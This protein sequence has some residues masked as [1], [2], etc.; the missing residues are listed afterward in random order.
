VS[1]LSDR[2]MDEV[3]GLPCV[4]C[5]HLGRGE[6]YGVE[7]HHLFDAHQRSDWLIAPLCPECH[8][9]PNGFHGLGGEPP[10]RRRYKVGEVELLAMTL[11]RFHKQRRAA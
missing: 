7:L 3:G 11:E 5:L 10:F 4:L 6:V 8:R 2:W 1:V 9:G